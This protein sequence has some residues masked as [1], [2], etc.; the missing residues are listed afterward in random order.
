MNRLGSISDRPLP[1]GS[2]ENRLSEVRSRAIKAIFTP[3]RVALLLLTVLV[4]AVYWGVPHFDFVHYDDHVYVTDHAQVRQGLTLQGLKWAMTSTEAGFWHPLTWLSLMLDYRLFGLNPGGY[5][6]TNLLLHLANT[7]LLF[8]V[9]AS[10]TSAV[11]RSA[12]VAALFGVHPL[13]VESVA[14]IAERK[15]LLCGLFWVLALGAYARYAE[16]PSWARYAAVFIAVFLALASKAMAVTLPFILLLLDV[17]PL[18]RFRGGIHGIAEAT[19]MRGDQ[20][21]TSL[22]TESSGGEGLPDIPRAERLQGAQAEASPAGA[23]HGGGAPARFQ[24]A[25]L[26]RL[27]L[28]K[29]PLVAL[30]AAVAVLTVAAE[31]KI[32]AIKTVAEYPMTVRVENAFVSYV[33]YLGKTLWPANLAVIYPHPGAWPWLSVALS[34]LILMIIS[35][36]AFKLWR[37][38]PYLAVGWFWYLGALVPVIGFI[39]IGSHAMA[40]RYTYLP[41]IGLFIMIAWGMTDLASRWTHGRTLLAIWGVIAVAVLIPVARAQVAHWENAERLFR[42]ALSVTVNNDI[43]HNNL[44]AALARQGRFDEALE[45]CRAALAIRPAYP[46]ALFNAGTAMAGRDRYREAEAYY[47]KAI[48]LRPEFA[49]AHN[50]LAIALAMQ[51]K[52]DAAIGHFLTALRLRP[53]Y[54]EA[55]KNLGVAL[56]R[57]GNDI[58]HFK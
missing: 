24:R 48:S 8:L 14:W 54:A 38:A 58:N 42:H 57:M 44:A 50:N 21:E 41:L 52:I 39:Q 40:D 46:E 15:D 17:W 32:G 1:P 9:L 49:E 4:L 35:V 27:I 11:W 13:H 37:R 51:G 45:Q 6:F 20:A 2:I 56:R 16:R 23:R 36:F 19:P 5:H 22:A 31:T 12:F 55:E 3:S 7:L 25:T 29:I 30:S 34:A 18:R 53:D 26:F 10:M 47:R 43:A 28:E 33:R